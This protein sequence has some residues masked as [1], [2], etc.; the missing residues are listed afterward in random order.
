MEFLGGLLDLD[1]AHS[2]ERQSME[3]RHTAERREMDARQASEKHECMTKVAAALSFELTANSGGGGDG[4]LGP[5]SPPAFGA[6]PFD[7]EEQECISS[8]DAIFRGLH[9]NG[10]SVDVD[11]DFTIFNEDDLARQHSELQGA[12]D[13]SASAAGRDTGPK[14]K[15]A[16]PGGSRLQRPKSAAPSNSTASK[17]KRRQSTSG[18][19]GTRP[20][21]GLDTTPKGAQESKPEKPVAKSEEIGGASADIAYNV[22]KRTQR[23]M[24]SKEFINSIEK[25]R[26]T[27]DKESLL[28]KVEAY[29]NVTVVIR[30]R[31]LFPHE[32]ERGEFDVVSCIPGEGDDQI[33]NSTAAAVVHNCGEKLVAGRGMVKYLTSFT[34]PCQKVYDENSESADVYHECA[35]PLVEIAANGGVAT[36]F[37]YGQT[38]SGKTHTMTAI[39]QHTS[40]DIFAMCAG[41]SVYLAYFE[42]IGK[43]CYDLMDDAHTEVFLKEGKDKNIHIQG[44]G[45]LQVEDPEQLKVA[46]K[47]ALGRRETASTGVNASSS[48]SHAVCRIRIGDGKQR[49][50]L[51][52][53]DLAGSERKHDSMYH[54]ADRRRECSE[55]NSS[56]MSLKECIR[57]R[58]LA[59]KDPDANVHVPYRGSTLTRVL[60]DSLD[61]P[62]AHTC[63]I[64]TSSPSAS[65]TEH[66][67]C[68]FDTVSRLTG[69]ENNVKENAEEVA[70]MRPP[71][72][73]LVHPQKW[74]AA[75]MQEWL[76]K[77][78]A[79]YKDAVAKVP[80]SMNGKMFMQ[81]S[82]ERLGQMMDLKSIDKALAHQLYNRF[83]GEVKKV[84][85]EIDA[86]RKQVINDMHT[87]K[88]VK[89]S[90]SASF[91]PKMS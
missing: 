72:V 54:D 27:T 13:A 67:M 49:G 41:S 57:Y 89:S 75:E 15:M 64:A 23:K 21:L 4:I 20:P 34:Y 16:P 7:F 8:N 88:H 9:E 11:D 71:P 45:E 65:D 62:A 58:A 29:G 69:G 90:F 53:V 28:T 46:M 80:S 51:T 82:V 60:K 40:E 33:H 6:D 79:K 1:E 68:T 14:S 91:A 78:P 19:A 76:G 63:V 24:D 2:E 12:L 86:R 36:C 25:W 17:P 37:M 43:R 39:Q 32:D 26:S 52:L 83:R 66:T 48:R 10:L 81:L 42:L 5:V 55:I 38:G 74:S 44:A 73:E 50:M 18:A 31:P 47:A 35:A 77:L 87:K 30:K 85:D 56:L 59:A 3:A 70:D 84:Q 22:D 61:S